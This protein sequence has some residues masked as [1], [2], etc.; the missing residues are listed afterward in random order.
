MTSASKM[1]DNVIIRAL[2]AKRLAQRAT[3]AAVQIL[4]KEGNIFTF[5][6]AVSQKLTRA[7]YFTKYCET[8]TA[9]DYF[10]SWRRY[11]EDPIC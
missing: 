9:T 3:D 7:A 2:Y 11:D 6:L 5:S 4:K 8:S 10:N 1:P